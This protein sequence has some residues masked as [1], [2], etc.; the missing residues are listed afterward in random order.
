MDF[1]DNLGDS[2]NTGL[3]S[4]VSAGAAYGATLLKPQQNTSTPQS[5]GA[6]TKQNAADNSGIPTWAI[7]A[8]IG[9]VLLVVGFV[10]F[11]K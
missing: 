9:L 3:S 8:G 5:S 11:R 7:Y 4:L 2:L 1:L 6:D 10:A